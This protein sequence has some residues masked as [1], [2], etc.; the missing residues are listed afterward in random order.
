MSNYVRERLGQIEDLYVN[1]KRSLSQIA[2]V[3]DLTGPGVGYS[4][5]QMHIPR[6]KKGGNNNGL[7][8][9][10]TPDERKEMKRLYEEEKLSAT[11]IGK[12]I[13]KNCKISQGT[14]YKELRSIGVK[15]RLVG[16]PK[17][18]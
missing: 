8:I 14:I 6:R 18:L 1:K 11:K 10:F 3:F 13:R 2:N 7:E 12:I 17:T 5:K 15:M 16:R 9:I 4:L